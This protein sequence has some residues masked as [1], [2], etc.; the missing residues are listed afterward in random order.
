MSVVEYHSEERIAY[1]RLNRPEAKNAISKEVHDELN[2]AW[3]RI[4][5]DDSVDVVILTGTGDSFCG[6]MDLKTHVTQY[7]GATPQM[8]ADWV[9]LGLGGLTRGKHRFKK[10]VIAAVNGW[11][12][13]GG[14][15]L[16]MSADIRIASDQAKFGSFEARRGFH[17]GD[18]GLVR[19]V[20][21]CGVSVAMEMALTAEP[22][23]AQR[24]LQINLV[25]K[26]VPHDQLMEA[27]K[28]T[29][30]TILRN[31]QAAVRSAKQVILDL[32]GRNLDDQLYKEAIAAYTLMANNPTVPG[33]LQK[34]Y[35]KTDKG[36][37]GANKTDL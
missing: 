1:V 30:R 36:R 6:G 19:L 7:V 17:H 28:Q 32:I 26:V 20:N 35:E 34:F 10:P 11:A 15:E 25:S 4:A 2:A 9:A 3:D 18:G 23:D 13:A 37:H 21:H 31:D 14:F 24:A 12:L 8:I 27:A 5:V 33:L 29:A 22:I 16:A